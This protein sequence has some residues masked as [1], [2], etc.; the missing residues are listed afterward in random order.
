M[1]KAQTLTHTHTSQTCTHTHTPTHI[2]THTPLH[3][4]GQRASQHSCHEAL[5]PCK[6]STGAN[7]STT[8]HAHTWIQDHHHL[9]TSSSCIAQAHSQATECC[10]LQVPCLA[11]SPSHSLSRRVSLPL[12]CL[13]D[14]TP[15][16]L[17][18]MSTR[19]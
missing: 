9:H 17:R 18:Y 10:S 12:M 6:E 19:R 1:Q 5:F 14:L 15:P 4:A 16:T 11:H 7:S 8:Q 2:Y 3:Y 13:G